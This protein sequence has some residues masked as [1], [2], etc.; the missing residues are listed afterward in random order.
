MVRKYLA[1]GLQG[2]TLTTLVGALALGGRQTYMDGYL[3]LQH[4]RPR[5]G[6]AKL[7]AT[8]HDILAAHNL[9]TIA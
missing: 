9:G 8:H 1:P 7:V 2:N 3:N 6:E 4:A 5:D